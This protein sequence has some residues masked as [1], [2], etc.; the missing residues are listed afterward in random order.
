MPDGDPQ[1]FAF[2]AS[3]DEDGYLA[4]GRAVERLG[5]LDPGSYSVSEDVPAG[6]DLTSVD[7]ARDSELRERDRRCTA[8]ETV[9]CAFTNTKRGTIIVEKQTSPDKA[10]GSFSF[11]G[12]CGRLDRRRRPDRRRQPPAGHVHVDRG[13]G[14]GLEPDSIACD[15]ANSTGSLGTRTATF[16]LEAGEVVKCTFTN[17]KL[18]V[19]R[20]PSTSRSRRTRRP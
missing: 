2:S 18:T 15:D 12:D 11:S 20:A 19:G 13:R 6:W 14:R 9:T 10:S 4:L 16:Q 8:G 7:C 5:D 3:Y 17:A 1:V